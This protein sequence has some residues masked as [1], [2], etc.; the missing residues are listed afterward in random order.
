MKKARPVI[1]ASLLFSAAI[2]N[3]QALCFKLTNYV[4]EFKVIGTGSDGLELI[5]GQDYAIYGIGKGYAL[6]LVGG[7]FP[8]VVAA[9]LESVGLHGLNGGFT[10]SS[11]FGGHSDCTFFYNQS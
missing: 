10:A 8:K 4:D 3:A 7:P 5:F 2:G 6:P 1:I 11:G 9:S